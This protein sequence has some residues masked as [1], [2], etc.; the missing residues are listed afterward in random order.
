MG[1]FY[2]KLPSS[3]FPSFKF[4]CPSCFLCCTVSEGDGGESHPG[5]VSSKN[6]HHVTSMQIWETMLAQASTDG[7]IVVAN[8][9]A[10]WSLPCKEIM[11]SYCHL[12]DTYSSSLLFLTVDADQLAELSTSWS[13][14]ATPTFYFLKEGNQVEKLVGADKVELKKKTAFAADLVTKSRK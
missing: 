4:A 2:S 9:V 3:K 14:N 7:K 13:V 5:E 10:S 1:S 12:A 11:P 6:V 8:F